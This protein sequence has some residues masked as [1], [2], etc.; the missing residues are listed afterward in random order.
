MIVTAHLQYRGEGVHIKIMLQ[1]LNISDMHHRITYMCI[2]VLLNQVSRS[3]RTVHTNLLQVIVSY[4][5][6]QLAI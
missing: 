3:V 5:N 4:I 1:K 2:N 6:L